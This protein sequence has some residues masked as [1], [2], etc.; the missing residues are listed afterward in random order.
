MPFEPGGQSILVALQ[1][2]AIAIEYAGGATSA[3]ALLHCRLPGR[4]WAGIGMDIGG[5]AHGFP[6]VGGI[7]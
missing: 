1:G 4:Q 3:A 6:E 2:L 7:G 5:L